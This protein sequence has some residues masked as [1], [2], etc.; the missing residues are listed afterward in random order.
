LADESKKK[1]TPSIYLRKLIRKT[2][3]ESGYPSAKVDTVLSEVE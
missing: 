1:P 3:I 2:L